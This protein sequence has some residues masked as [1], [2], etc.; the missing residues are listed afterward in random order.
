MQIQ[1]RCECGI[2]ECRE[3]ALLEL[4]GV[5]E[6]QPSAQH[7]PLNAFSIGS[8]CRSQQEKYYF[9][10]GYHELEGKKV[11][12][13]KP[14]LVLQKVLREDPIDVESSPV[15]LSTQYPTQVQK[16]SELKAIGIIR[17]KI[18]FKTRPKALISSSV[19]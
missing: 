2:S 15:V 16:T 5:L 12:L 19:K 13:K 14:M 9:T 10:I 18:L 8:L 11:S 17:H 4:Q 1:V 3:W 7:L 6:I